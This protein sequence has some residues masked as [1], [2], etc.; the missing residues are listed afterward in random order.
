[1][2]IQS[3]TDHSTGLSDHLTNILT[4]ETDHGGEPQVH[5]NVLDMLT[6]DTDSLWSSTL[7]YL[8]HT[9][10]TA[11]FGTLDKVKDHP[12]RNKAAGEAAQTF[13][14]VWYGNQQNPSNR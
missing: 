14:N 4:T 10:T 1:M 9:I 12:E 8:S 2:E 5:P 11:D 3:H 7:G 13:V 6:R